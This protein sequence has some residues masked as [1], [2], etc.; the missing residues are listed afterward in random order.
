M[1]AGNDKT[2]SRPGLDSKIGTIGHP[3]ERTLYGNSFP[4]QQG[5]FRGFPSLPKPGYL[6]RFSKFEGSRLSRFDMLHN[7]VN[8][9]SHAELRAC[10]I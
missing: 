10:D 9:E 5:A 3:T 4:D 7:L 1:L 2:A 6:D 8:V